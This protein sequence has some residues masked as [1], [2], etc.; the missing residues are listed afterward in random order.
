MIMEKIQIPFKKLGEIRPRSVAE[1]RHSG[2]TLGC[3]LIDRGYTDY[4]EYKEYISPLGIKTIRLQGGWARTEQTPG[5][6]RFE[7]LDEIIDDAASRGLNILLETGYGNPVYPG[8]GGAN[9]A[10][11]FPTSEEGLNAWDRWV[12]AM[13]NRYRNTVR[14]WAMWNEPDI[15]SYHTP[16]Q[17]VDFNIRTAKIIREIIPDARI[18]GL[19]LASSN[20][21]LFEKCI[22]LLDDLHALPLFD[23]FIYHGYK[24]NP[25]EAY[26]VGNK[27]KNVLEKYQARGK[28][29][30]GENGCPSERSGN[31]AIAEHDWTEI[32][33]SKWNLRR[34]IG[35][36]ANNVETAVFT[37]CDYTQEKRG[38]NRKGLLLTDEHHKVI[39]KKMVYHA[40]Q[41]MTAIFDD[42]LIPVQGKGAVI[43]RQN[44]AFFCFE[45]TRKN[46]NL[47]VYWDRSGI[48]DD[49]LTLNTAQLV[50]FDFPFREPVLTEMIS[51]A[52]FEIPKER[53]HRDNKRLW[54]IDMPIIDSPFLIA[55]RTILS[56]K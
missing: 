51:G 36:V 56:L 13:A 16:E 27:L 47:L 32:S 10:G 52:V 3:E 20:A 4:N 45:H 25:D 30:Q 34:F 1:I 49:N 12:E 55:E 11:G 14:D 54:F 24:F 8:G 53:I 42:A 26:E 48:P 6:Y 35:D 46:E 28:L 33:Q 18:A 2:F 41:H 39:R 19:S 21:N 7:W 22:K 38:I 31:Y 23:W 40:I 9:L 37:I 44:S 50:T 5:I 17:I 29:R 43:F 15:V